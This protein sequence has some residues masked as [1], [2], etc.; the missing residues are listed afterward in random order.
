MKESI[1]L[2]GTYCFDKS[3]I[4]LNARQA[5]A[6]ESAAK[7]NPNMTVYLLFLSPLKLSNEAKHFYNILTKYKDVKIKRLINKDYFKNTPLE[8]WFSIEK[9]RVTR[10]PS[11][12]M[13]DI[14]WF[15]TMRKYGGIYLDLDVVVIKYFIFYLNIFFIIYIILIFI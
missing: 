15:I 4:D 2:F 5:C 13:S 11:T 8:N 14:L 6:V 9:L 3:G 7:M 1:F 12:I 10:W